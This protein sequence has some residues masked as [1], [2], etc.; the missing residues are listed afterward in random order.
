[1]YHLFAYENI[2]HSGYSVENQK[3]VLQQL[4]KSPKRILQVYKEVVCQTHLLP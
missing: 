4:Q 2:A 3:V 1:M